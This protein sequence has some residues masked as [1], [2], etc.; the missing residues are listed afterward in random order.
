MTQ[1]ILRL[2]IA[3]FCLAAFNAPAVAADRWQLGF[4]VMCDDAA[5][6]ARLNE[7]IRQR[8]QKADIDTTAKIPRGKLMVYA[9]RDVRDLKNKE[10]VSFAVAHISMMHVARVLIGMHDRQEP[11]PKPLLGLLEEQGFLQALNAEHIEDTSE[12]RINRL[13]DDVVDAFLQYYPAPAK[14]Q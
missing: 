6:A 7:G 3:C 9:A 11:L 10:G 13:L 14:T 2:L 8:L 12:A 4:E 5:L 1:R